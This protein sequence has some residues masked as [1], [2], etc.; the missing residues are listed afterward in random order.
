MVFSAGNERPLSEH[1]PVLADYIE[2]HYVEAG[3]LEGVTVR[4]DRRRPIVGPSSFPGLPC[5][6]DTTPVD[7]SGR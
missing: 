2:R 7:V 1:W 3:T 6:V 5:F 4:I